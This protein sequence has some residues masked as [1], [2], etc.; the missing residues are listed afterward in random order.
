[1]RV[2]V[3]KETAPGERRVALVP[4]V[5]QRWPRPGS[6]WCSS[7]AP[8][9]RPTSPTPPTRR[10]ARRSATGLAATWWPRSAPPTAEEIGR[11]ARR[12]G[13]DRLPGAAHQRP[14]P[15]RALAGAGVTSFAMEAIPRIT[16]AQSMDAL[17]SQATV[18]GYR[19][20][21]IAAAGAGQV[22]PDAHHR[23][24]HRAPRP[25]CWC[26]APASPACRRSPPRAGSARSSRPSTCAPAV[27]EQVES[28]GRQVR[29]ARHGTR[30]RREGGRL[31]ARSSPRRSSAASRSCWPSAIAPIDAVI[32]TA[33]VPGRPAPKLVDRAGGRRTCSPAR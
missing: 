10:R 27:K 4:E 6:T 32:T 24:R 2:S 19:A 7:P 25:R 1:M 21:L 9:R 8:A 30:G 31:R 13:A 14:T 5:V 15:S 29:R 28:L 20:A 18:A 23:G 33:A 22:L 3:P 26:S 11:L 12:L 16:R 17:S